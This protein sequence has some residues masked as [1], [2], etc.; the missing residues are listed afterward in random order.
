MS[1]T[2]TA[3]RA[4][5]ALLMSLALLVAV[6]SSPRA[7]DQGGAGAANAATTDQLR[8]EPILTDS[9]RDTVQTLLRLRDS[10]TPP[11]A[12]TARTGARMART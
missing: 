10:S 6:A 4:V 2:S 1:P 12:R 5:L 11:W 8:T 9:P 3:S 7:Q